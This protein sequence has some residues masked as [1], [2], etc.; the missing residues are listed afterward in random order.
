MFRESD[1]LKKENTMTK[2]ILMNVIKGTARQID[3][4]EIIKEQ[5]QFI[6]QAKT[7]AGSKP[8]K[9]EETY[10]KE[11]EKKLA[12]LEDIVKRWVREAFQDDDDIYSKTEYWNKIEKNYSIL[13]H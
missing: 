6:R 12:E 2:E 1:F 8:S 5:Y 7:I 3:F 4:M 11:Q 13:F 9:T 10:I